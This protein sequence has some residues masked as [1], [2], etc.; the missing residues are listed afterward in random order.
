VAAEISLAHV[1]SLPP[2]RM[3]R[4]RW[5]IR[6]KSLSRVTCL[7]ARDVPGL[8]LLVRAEQR[9]SEAGR[10]LKLIRG[11]SQIKRL[12]LLGGVQPHFQ[13]IARGET[14]PE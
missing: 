14:N 5:R 1:S 2:H 9:L 11:P 3:S 8:Q 10:T 6:A 12:F 13:F 7:A 4:C